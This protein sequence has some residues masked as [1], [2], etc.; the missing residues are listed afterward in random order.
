MSPSASRWL[1][2]PCSAVSPSAPPPVAPPPSPPPPQRRPPPTPGLME[3]NAAFSF[4]AILLVVLTDLSGV[5]QAALR[6]DDVPLSLAVL[7]WACFVAPVVAVSSA[8]GHDLAATFSLRP[9][10]PR[11]AASALLGGAC[12]WPL[13][14]AV[15][16]LRDGGVAA[17]GAEASYRLVE[18]GATLWA[19]PSSLP[20]AL[21]LLF[22]GVLSPSLAEELLFRGYLLTALRAGGLGSV[23]ACLLCAALFAAFHLSFSMFFPLAVLGVACGAATVRSTSHSPQPAPL[24][25]G[26][27]GRDG[28]AA[29][30]DA[31]L[32]RRLAA[33]TTTSVVPGV[34]VHAGYNAA[35]LAY[36]VGTMRDVLPPGV[37]PDWLVALAAAGAAAALAL[38][39]RTDQNQDER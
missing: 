33:V 39:A 1:S 20:E 14:A 6:S 35:A 11:L 30:A 32:R 24:E 27:D 21:R 10:S 26:D 18:G 19:P 23:D 8:A 34:L 5:G 3:A 12:L 2:P 38:G 7:Q 13:L 28:G 15:T 9:C 25:G 37:P 22:Y 17:D 36:G 16:S 31:A 4:G 29:A